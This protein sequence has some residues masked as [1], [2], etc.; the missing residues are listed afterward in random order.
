MIVY[1][2][3]N[4]SG[5]LPGITEIILNS[6]FTVGGDLAATELTEPL[7]FEMKAQVIELLKRIHD[8]SAS[9][10]HNLGIDKL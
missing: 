4:T 7:P 6:I 10:L 5:T 3:F 2:K 9:V 8:N 1:L